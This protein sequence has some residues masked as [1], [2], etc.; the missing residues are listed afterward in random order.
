MR[1]IKQLECVESIWTLIQIAKYIYENRENLNTVVNNI[2]L[3]SYYYFLAVIIVLWLWV[4]L[5][6]IF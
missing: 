5:I 6:I 3:R 4:S 2:I 1:R